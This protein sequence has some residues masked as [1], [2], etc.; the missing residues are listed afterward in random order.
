MKQYNSLDFEEAEAQATAHCYSFK[1]LHLRLMSDDTITINEM[2]V[3][4]ALGQMCLTGD[5]TCFPSR[6]EIA[7]RAKVSLRTVSAVLN[8]L[9]EKGYIFREERHRKDGSLTSSLYRVRGMKFSKAKK[10]HPSAQAAPG[11]AGGTP[12]QGRTCTTYNKENLTKKTNPSKG[13]PVMGGEQGS[14]RDDDYR[15]QKQKAE[16]HSNNQHHPTIHNTPLTEPA[17]SKQR[18]YPNYQGDENQEARYL[19]DPRLLGIGYI[20]NME[21]PS[22][23]L[24]ERMPELE[25]ARWV[26]SRDCS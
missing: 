16:A 21:T 26:G 10:T 9:E 17:V 4:L 19:L 6:R 15:V 13:T 7:Q 12:P 18:G 24:S 11:R 22:A 5:G 25:S 14:E 1:Q 2:S 8:S 20:S 23:G 3:A